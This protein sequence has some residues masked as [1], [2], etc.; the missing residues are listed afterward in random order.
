[1]R[2][3]CG[4]EGPAKE[5]AKEPEEVLK[6]SKANAELLSSFSGSVGAVI[7]LWPAANKMEAQV[8]LHN[9]LI[10]LGRTKITS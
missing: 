9:D 3:I 1:M 5:K 10:R 8:D 6:G 4:F 7:H 2:I